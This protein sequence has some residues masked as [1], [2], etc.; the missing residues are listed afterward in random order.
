MI[1]D[2]ERTQPSGDSVDLARGAA[3]W[4]SGLTLSIDSWQRWVWGLPVVLACAYL[5]VLLVDFR[6][7]IT[8]INMYGDAIIAP[9]M[10]KL[11]GQAPPGSQVVLGHHPYYE[12]FLFLRAS[13]GLS[14]YRRLWEVVPL[15]WTALG[16]GMLAWSARRAFG[17]YAAVLTASALICFGA[18]G[19]YS[20]FTFDWH[21]L[22][23]IHT[24]LLGAALV[25]LTPRASDISWG[26]VSAVAVALGLIS[27]LPA[28]SDVLFVFWALI[29]M[30][31]A[32]AVMASRSVGR[33]R[34][35][36]LVFTL[37]TVLVSLL[38]GSAIAHVMR[39]HGI[40][41]SQP[42]YTF[43]SSFAAGIH[44]L[45]LMVEGFMALGGGDFFGMKLAFLGLI[46]FVS[47]ALIV[48]A[49]L[50]GLRE[51]RRFS[52]AAYRA[53]VSRRRPSSALVYV[54]FWATSLVVQAVVFVLTSVPKV[55]TGSSRYVLAGYVAII[56]LVPLL[57]RG[58]VWRRAVVTAGVC[59]FALSGVIQ[60]A[61]QPFASFGPY[62][63]PTVADR[64]LSFARAHDVHYGYAGYWDAPDLT[65]LTRFNLKI[66]PIQSG[67]GV[68]GICAAS[69][70]QIN[71]WYR[72]RPGVRSM[73][74][75]DSALPGVSSIDGMLG[76][77]L[78][79]ARI[80]TLTVAIYPFDIASRF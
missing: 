52:V 14:F 1:T 5:I 57:A 20:F 2:S 75:A 77:P 44:N 49:L 39:A 12:E 80:G 11:L 6:D 16:V 72:A 63:T 65:W 19:R 33:A 67:C 3:G 61:R 22:T 7:V 32:A 78:S 46:V 79:I 27:A 48:A 73:L 4:R 18:L 51:A 21:A 55:T 41:A 38:A 37:I 43:V 70:A 50:L 15:L 25:W 8:S 64:V 76:R 35:T 17:G 40:T 34:W 71:T 56:A 26:A 29:P 74:I 68:E 47:G 36:P 54:G 9:V 30:C 45:E 62:P 31:V 53:P 42:A 59:L 69:P 58:R 28:A 23:V 60:L 13:A 66:Y 10:A 24:I